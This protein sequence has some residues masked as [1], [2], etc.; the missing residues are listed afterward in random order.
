[1]TKLLAGDSHKG[2]P[3][4]SGRSATHAQA[5]TRAYWGRA[6]AA[7]G[8]LGSSSLPQQTLVPSTLN[9]SRNQLL[10]LAGKPSALSKVSAPRE[11]KQA[12]EGEDK[13]C[14]QE[15]EHKPVAKPGPQEKLES[16]YHS[17]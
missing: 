10:G 4:A 8:S 5:H 6:A 13:T 2:N 14:K 12:A 9:L 17:F 16:V 7:Q 1:M 11:I 3:Q 15:V